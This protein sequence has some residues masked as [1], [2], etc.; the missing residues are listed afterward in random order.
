MTRYARVR[1][2][3]QG[4]KLQN[5]AIKLYMNKADKWTRAL[6]FMLA[7]LKVALQWLIKRTSDDLPTLQQL[8]P[9]GPCTTAD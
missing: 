4:E 3:V 6:K 1:A 8:G 7:N 5:V 9:E 2:C